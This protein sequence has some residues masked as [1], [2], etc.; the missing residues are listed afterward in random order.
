MP[1]RYKNIRLIKNSSDRRYRTN[2]IYPEIP[3]SDEDT[4]VIVTATDRYDTLAARYYGDSSLWW[5]IASANTSAQRA[6]LNPTPGQQIR[7][8]YNKQEVINSFNNLNSVR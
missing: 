5:I 7:I 6:T 4:Y 1:N 3:Q 2:A 8:P